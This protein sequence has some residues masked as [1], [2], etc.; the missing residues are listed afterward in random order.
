M[1]RRVLPWTAALALACGGDALAATETI[2]I[3]GDVH[4]VAF[5]GS[6]LIVA[7]HP[8][9]G[10]VVVERRAP[11]AAPQLIYTEPGG[12]AGDQLVLAAS[13]DAVALAIQAGSDDL[14]PNRV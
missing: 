10:G 6:A 7:R 14:S 4:A 8:A 9:K 1:L 11:G 2:P 12:D 3:K 5:S 13:P